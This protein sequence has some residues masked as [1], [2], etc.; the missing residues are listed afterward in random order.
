MWESKTK[1]EGGIERG[2]VLFSSIGGGSLPSAALAK[3]QLPP[4]SSFKTC[5]VSLVCLFIFFW[6]KGK[7]GKG[8]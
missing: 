5:G 8:G 7:E 4:G 2:G 1:E 3:H 6:G